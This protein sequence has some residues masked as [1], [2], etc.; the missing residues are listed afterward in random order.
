MGWLLP[1]DW[2]RSVTAD[3]EAEFLDTLLTTVT[4][5]VEA[6][7]AWEQNIRRVEYVQAV[8]STQVQLSKTRF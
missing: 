5:A 1:V 2:I 4:D 6:D 8:A 7:I 3:S